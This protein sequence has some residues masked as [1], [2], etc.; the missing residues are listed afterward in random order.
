MYMYYAIVARG[1]EISYVG[2]HGVKSQSEPDNIL[3]RGVRC[4]TDD[5]G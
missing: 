5:T 4:D 3:L 1:G 2:D